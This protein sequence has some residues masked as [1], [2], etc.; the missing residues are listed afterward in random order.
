MFERKT[1]KEKARSE[2]NPPCPVTADKG[3]WRAACLA[4]LFVGCS[5]VGGFGCLP[6]Q[7]ARSLFVHRLGEHVA[8]LFGA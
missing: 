8:F 1:L 6:W 2:G 5:H 3:T 7:E 4:W